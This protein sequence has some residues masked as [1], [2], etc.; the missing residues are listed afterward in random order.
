MQ[1]TQQQLESYIGSQLQLGQSPNNI[2]AQLTAA[3]RPTEHVDAAFKA[4]Q[5]RIV[6]LRS[7]GGSTPAAL[8]RRR[9]RIGTGWALFKQSVRILNGNRYLL[10]YFAM[11]WVMV[12]AVN[13]AI[14]GIIW[15][16]W[17]WLFLHNGADSALWW[18]VI[19]LNY[20]VVYL[21]INFYA[22]ALSSNILDIFRGEKRPFGEYTAQARGRFGP[23]FVYSLIAAVIG[24]VLEYIVERIKF[25]GWILSWLLG[26]AWSIGTMFVLPIIMS[27]DS[28]APDAIKQSMRFFKQTWG[29]GITAKATVNLPLALINIALAILFIPFILGAAGTGNAAIFVFAFI[30]YVIVLISLAVLGSFANNIV[31]VALYYYAVNRQVPPGFSSDM[32]NS[33]FIKRKRRFLRKPTK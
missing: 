26:T 22:A 18:I 11:T 15:A 20:L 23:I 24:I 30:L 4:I 3:G 2:A 33:V 21:A 31:N 32:L 27:T 7:A 10:R 12:L 8:G 19:L 25:I 13:I 16:A 6:P 14:V 17:K 5:A 9:G 28:S 1:D 29:E